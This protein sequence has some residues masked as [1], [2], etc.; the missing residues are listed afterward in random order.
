MNSSLKENVNRIAKE[1]GV[2]LSQ[3]EKDL[4]FSEKYL[5][6]LDK[7]NPSIDRVV[8]M[9]DYL[10]VSVDELVGYEGEYDKDLKH[11]M[12]MAS[13]LTEDQ[14]AALIAVAEQLKG[15]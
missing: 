2:S 7:N 10:H 13:W 1:R 9:A 6:K 8:A 5:S 14:L 11:L 15:K 12:E 3:M 4:G